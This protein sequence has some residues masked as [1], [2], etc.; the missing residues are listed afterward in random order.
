MLERVLE[1]DR[2]YVMARGYAKF[3]LFNA[4]VLHGSSDVCRLRENRAYE[5]AEERPLTVRGLPSALD[6]SNFW[7]S[8]N[9]AMK[10]SPLSSCPRWLWDFNDRITC[11]FGDS[12][13][14][15]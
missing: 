15:Q 9:S 6:Q 3:A 4:I 8:G 10:D 1:H 14:A 12:L 2:L 11:S 7:S 13:N 5:I